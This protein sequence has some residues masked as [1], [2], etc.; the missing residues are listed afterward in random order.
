ADGVRDGCELPRTLRM[1]K[2]APAWALFVDGIVNS[3]I[4]VAGALV[5]TLGF[6]LLIGA[7][8]GSHKAALH[9]PARL[10]TITMQSSPVV[11]TLVIAAAFAQALVPYSST[12]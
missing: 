6:A 5:A 12:V 10:V 1:L 8:L 11:L 4:L 2:T 7:A 3:L 9:W